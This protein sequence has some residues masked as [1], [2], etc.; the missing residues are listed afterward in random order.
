MKSLKNR[1]LDEEIEQTKATVLE[2][3]SRLHAKETYLKSL[4]EKFEELQVPKEEN[5]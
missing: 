5:K 1:L 4:N 2:L 3:R